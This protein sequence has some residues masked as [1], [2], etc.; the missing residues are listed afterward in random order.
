MAVIRDTIP[1]GIIVR[2]TPGVTRWAT[3]SWRVSALL[4]GAGPADW[5]ELRR[6]GDAV[7]FHA[8]T[9]TLELFSS[10]TQGYVVSLAS[11][12][13]CLYVVLSEDD[14]A[15]AKLPWKPELLTASAFEGQGYAESGEGLVER[16]PMPLP[17]ISFVRDFVQAHHVEEEFAK[18]KRDR[19]RVDLVEDGKGDARIRQLS[20]VYRAPRPIRGDVH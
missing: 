18:R 17:L 15:D 7:E 6:E 14:S 11:K 4:P 2:R 9:M 8:A 10:D 12:T 5:R 19:K 20:D 1:V 13:P 16:V 3:W